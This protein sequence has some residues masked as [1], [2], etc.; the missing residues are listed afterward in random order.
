M[1]QNNIGFSNFSPRVYREEGVCPELIDAVSAL[2]HLRSSGKIWV[3]TESDKWSSMDFVERDWL[4]RFE[5]PEMI[6]QILER[7]GPKKPSVG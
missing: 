3:K 2:K 6:R 5:D 1:D 7:A 4:A